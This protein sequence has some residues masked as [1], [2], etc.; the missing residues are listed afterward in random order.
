M[1]KPA[2]ST[3]VDS[4]RTA[5]EELINQLTLLRM[6]LQQRQSQTPVTLDANL[7]SDLGFDSLARAEMMQRIEKHFD[8]RLP[9]QTVTTV[10]TPR[11]LLREILKC[12]K[13][14]Q[15]A[16]DER[17]L[18]KIELGSVESEPRF[19]TTL[20]G[21]LQWHLDKHRHRTHLFLYDDADQ[22]IEVS[23]GEL[24][25]Q[26]ARIAEALLARGLE[27]G[28]TVA[29]MLPT[30]KDYFTSF[31]GVLLARGVPVPIYPPARPSQLESH[32]RRHIG[33]LNN[34]LARFMI[35]VAEALLLSQFLRS[36][37]DSLQHITT[38]TA[39]LSDDSRHRHAEQ[40]NLQPQHTD[41]CMLQ[42]TS[43][44]TGNPK[45]VILSHDNVLA[46][47]R[48][49]G[50]ALEISAEDI[51]VSWLPLY[52][53]MGLIGAWFGSLY[54][55]APLV[56]MSPLRFLSNPGNWL[57]A[58]HRY[59]GTI[60]PAPNFAYELCLRLEEKHLEGLD[61]SSWRLTLNG[62]EP[63]SPNTIAR[64]SQRFSRY[65]F[66][67][68]AMAPVYGLAESSVGLA[69]PPLGRRPLIDS[70]ERSALQRYGRAIPSTGVDG[71]IECVAL[72]QPLPG[73]EVRIV[74]AAGREL[75]EREEGELQF[76]GP[77]CTSGY[78]RNPEQ[79]ARLFDG[80]WLN[81]GDRAYLAGGEIYIT[82]RSK[83]IIIRAGRNIHP[84]ELEDAVGNIFGV[85]KGCVAVF[86]ATNN[87]SKT[88]KLIVLAET[89]LTSPQQQWSLR[90]AIKQCALD[91]AGIAADDVVIAP[92][93]T[94]PKTSSGKIRRSACR[95]LY[96]RG[97]LFKQQRSVFMQLVRLGLSALWP[98]LWK[99]W[100]NLRDLLY[101]GYSWS[102][103]VIMSCV[104]WT[105]VAI[106]P[107]SSLCWRLVQTFARTLLRLTGTPLKVR[108]VEQLPAS[109]PMIMVANHSSY[110]DG[111]VLMAALPH[112]VSFVAKAEFKKN[113]FTHIFLSRLKT[114]YVER[115]D[116][117]KGIDDAH[118]IAAA[119][120]DG[121][122]LLFF[123]EG[124][125]YRMP[126]LHGFHLGAFIV[127]AEAGIPVVP[128]TV[129]GTRSILR[130]GTWFPR[131]GAIDIAI[132]SP[133]TPTGQNW[134]AALDLRNK[135]RKIIL[136]HCGEPD[137]DVRDHS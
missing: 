47:I 106:I 79:N 1:S 40:L 7:E 17:A 21:V 92:P 74:D 43:G 73:H 94:V 18:V 60:S 67:P 130:G 35:T 9:L 42:Y 98:Q 55:A 63:V 22:V 76:R 53:D 27:P 93:H 71:A 119:S 37:I 82:G 32:L 4:A 86:A 117:Q 124:T 33:I 5:A 127:A 72:G 85:R 68:D 96:E 48:C 31:F 122:S 39:L 107:V 58:V 69:F 77:S 103:M 83:D 6:E 26:A 11:D 8:V 41:T 114:E 20:Q 111:M 116:T 54:F 115:F 30:C 59:R 112:P 101:A 15:A 24:H 19:E 128:V 84:F 36:Q 75:P 132:G 88:E 13:R 10:E 105:L 14:E 51:V 29:V 129:V 90:E 136:G 49:V 113:I 135:A 64:F 46:N 108:G 34:C 104:C 78:F 61:L 12:D 126:G 50:Q 38:P 100:R 120:Q 133:I 65:G 62:A 80:S 25:R 16:I 97:L 70:I 81:S 45:G 91:V 121:R 99:T 95:E 28:Q 23:Y 52:H 2:V 125:F 137:L 89:R 44:S 110:I 123:P 134:N 57:W 3:P 102:L 109:G 87:R 118:R 56:V 131:R 66:R